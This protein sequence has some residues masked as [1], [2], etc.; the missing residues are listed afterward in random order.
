MEEYTPGR[1]LN[2]LHWRELA[3]KSEVQDTGLWLS[4]QVDPHSPD[5]PI[6]DVHTLALTVNGQGGQPS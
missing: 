6:I 4:V 2:L 3:A 5:L 1:A